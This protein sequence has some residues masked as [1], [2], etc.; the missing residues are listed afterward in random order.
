MSCTLAA[1]SFSLSET[2]LVVVTVGKMGHT[3]HTLALKGSAQR[4][5]NYFC[6]H[7][8]GQRESHATLEV[9]R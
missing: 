9:N 7:A 8:V 5:V 2:L 3:N 4:R 6:S 1:Y